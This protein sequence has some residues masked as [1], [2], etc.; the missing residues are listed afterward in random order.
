V[1]AHGDQHILK[2]IVRC[3]APGHQVK[4]AGDIA[5]AGGHQW[6]V[7]AL[8]VLERVKHRAGRRVDEARKHETVNASY[9]GQFQA[10]KGRQHPCVLSARRMTRFYGYG[11]AA[12]GFSDINLFPAGDLAGED[13]PPPGPGRP[14]R[15]A[16]AKY[17]LAC[18]QWRKT[19]VI[20]GG[21][22]EGRCRT[23]RRAGS[24]TRWSVIR[25]AHAGKCC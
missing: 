16:G 25:P 2:I 18:R 5:R 24:G 19:G 7:K 20:V 1:A 6:H 17:K 23:L 10:G 8:L 3:Q 15:R 11:R 9:L 4:D 13:S 21:E 14:P 12:W 22:S